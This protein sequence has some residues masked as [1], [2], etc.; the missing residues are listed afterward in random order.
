[1]ICFIS[2]G[3]S[4]RLKFL[5]IASFHG[6]FHGVSGLTAPDGLAGCTRKRRLG[7]SHWMHLIG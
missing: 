3:R 1:M 2:K 6:L 5:G 7:S 4:R